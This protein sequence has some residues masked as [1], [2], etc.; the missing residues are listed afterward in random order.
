MD[1]DQ[2]VTSIEK[3]FLKNVVAII[4]FYHPSAKTTKAFF[5]DYA[6]ALCSEEYKELILEL[7]K[8]KI[9]LSSVALRHPYGI[10]F[11]Y[12]YIPHV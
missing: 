5:E 9:F 10:R 7:E 4:L 3:P 12:Y 11:F 1:S 2:Q 8:T 6:G